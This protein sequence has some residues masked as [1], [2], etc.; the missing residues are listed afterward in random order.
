MCTAYSLPGRAPQSPTSCPS[1]E[2]NLW[3]SKVLSNQSQHIGIERPVLVARLGIAG[4]A[5]NAVPM[6]VRTCSRQPV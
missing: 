5:R 4:N 6:R 3:L 2:L 1:C